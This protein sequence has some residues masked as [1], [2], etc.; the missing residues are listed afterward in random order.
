MPDRFY[1]VFSFLLISTLGFQPI[2]DAGQPAVVF[3][4]PALVGVHEISY[5]DGH[6]TTDVTQKT[7]EVVIPVS[8]VIESGERGNID[9]FRFDIYWN[10]NIYPLADYGPKTRTE[11]DIEGLISVEK[12]SSKN[13]GAGINLNGGYPDVVSG[14]AKI[15]LSKSDGTRLKYQEVPQHQLLVAS[16]T[17]QRGTGA[18]F[19]FHP[20]KR[21]SLEGGRDLIVAYRVP[22]SWRGGVLKVECRGEGHRK[23]IGSWSEPFEQSRAFVIPIYL[24][25]DDQA[26]RAAE[27]FV[28]SE[29]GLRQNWKRHQS[30]NRQPGSGIFGL[31]PSVS[32][33]VAGI[34]NQWVHYLI[35]SGSDEYLTRYRSRLPDGLA[36]AAEQFVSARKDLFQF[37]R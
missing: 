15:D 26:R 35:Q 7:I 5:A 12:N 37:S 18:F 17:V 30:R 32:T 21:E 20:S 22:Q 4:V 29:Q 24:E 14:T 1:F 6:T 3:D 2:L 34:P 16:G 27:D 13:I 31:T 19:R 10:R 8:A 23:I 11:S 36:D 25:G 9:E 28:R 33:S